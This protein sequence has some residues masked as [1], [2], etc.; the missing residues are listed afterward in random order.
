MLGGG[1]GSA[2]RVGV[3][4]TDQ[5]GIQRLAQ[6]AEVMAAEHTRADDGDSNLVQDLTYHARP[7]R[8]P[9][10]TGA[11]MATTYL[12][13]QQMKDFA[14][15]VEEVAKSCPRKLFE[16]GIPLA[17][18]GTVTPRFTLRSYPR[19]RRSSGI[20]LTELTNQ[21]RNALKKGLGAL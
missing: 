18:F 15:T 17:A 3:H 14:Q 1:Y 4:H 5:G 19:M 21:V 6:H 12:S 2:F 20:L 11:L 16:S 8:Y 13:P 9:K 7:A 10:H